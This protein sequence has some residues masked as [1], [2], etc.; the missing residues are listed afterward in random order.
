MFQ[1]FRPLRWKSKLLFLLEQL[2]RYPWPEYTRS[3]SRNGFSQVTAVFNDNV[4]I[5]FARQQVNEKLTAAKD[6]LPPNTDPKMGAVSTGLGEIYMWTIQYADPDNTKASDGNPGFQSDGSYL[7]PEG[8]LL[9]TEVRNRL[10]P[11]HPRL[12]NYEPSTTH[13][14]RRCRS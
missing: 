5:Y 4:D 10:P 9:K 6:N 7:T 3:L 14:S 1:A 8:H 12:D 13:D 2:Y 11:H